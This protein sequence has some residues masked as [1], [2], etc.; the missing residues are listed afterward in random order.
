MVVL[1]A[2]S[3]IRSLTMIK[4]QEVARIKREVYYLMGDGVWPMWAVCMKWYWSMCVQRY[5]IYKALDD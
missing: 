3:V 1:G 4:V 5:T 2:Q